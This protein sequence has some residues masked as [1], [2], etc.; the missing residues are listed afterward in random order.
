MVTT[1][2]GL[3]R[4]DRGH[5][6]RRRIEAVRRFARCNE[7]ISS[8]EFAIILPVLMLFLFSIITFASVLYIHVNMENAAREAVRR[9]AVADNVAC[10]SVDGLTIVPCTGTAVACSIPPK[11]GSAEAYA[12]TYLAGWSI[13]FQV[14]AGPDATDCSELTVTVDLADASEA[15]M[16]DVFGFFDGKSLSAEVVMREEA[17]CV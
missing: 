8:V 6:G 2:A 13:D 5:V 17:T 16:G 7:G 15:A 9:L 1:F 14:T 4:P 3:V 12:C 10:T 11:D